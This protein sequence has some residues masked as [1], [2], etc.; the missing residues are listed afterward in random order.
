MAQV[1]SFDSFKIVLVFLAVFVLGIVFIN[2]L[3]PLAFLF[4]DQILDGFANLFLLSIGAL[5][6]VVLESFLDVAWK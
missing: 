1:L 6:A 4:V 2:Q 5:A 3:F